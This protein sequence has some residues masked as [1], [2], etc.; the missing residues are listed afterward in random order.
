[1]REAARYRG[2]SASGAAASGPVSRALWAGFNL[3]PLAGPS[4]RC[5]WEG[6]PPRIVGKVERELP[7]HGALPPSLRLLLPG[8]SCQAWRPPRAASQ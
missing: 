1:M 7:T 2:H 6:L 5:K 4:V 8:P 3:Q